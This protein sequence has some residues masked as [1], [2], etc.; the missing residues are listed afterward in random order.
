MCT[1]LIMP[2]FLISPNSE[3]SNTP[4]YIGQ[5]AFDSW[6]IVTIRAKPNSIIEN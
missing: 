4:F 3:W 2:N 1:F 5:K 6:H